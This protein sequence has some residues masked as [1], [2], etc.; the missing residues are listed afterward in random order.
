MIGAGGER[1]CRSDGCGGSS[2]FD[3]FKLQRRVGSCLVDLVGLAGRCWQCH[4]PEEGA[5]AVLR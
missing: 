5:G 4:S 1:H 3:V 2:L